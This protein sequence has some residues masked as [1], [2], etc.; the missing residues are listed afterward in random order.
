DSRGR[1][2][3]GEVPHLRLRGEPDA[4]LHVMGGRGGRGIP[5]DGVAWDGPVDGATDAGGAEPSRVASGTAVER[6]CDLSAVHAVPADWRG[7]LCV[8]WIAP[9]DVSHERLHLPQL[10]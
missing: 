4:G 7:P 1:G 10:H 6:S 5:Y 8:L 3:G 2:G 9:D